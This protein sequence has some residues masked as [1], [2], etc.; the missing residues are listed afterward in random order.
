[1]LTLICITPSIQTKLFFVLFL[2]TA[3][4]DGDVS[5]LQGQLYIDRSRD[6]AYSEALRSAVIA[7]GANHNYFN[8]EWTPGLAVAPSNDDWWDSSDPVCGDTG[9]V[10]LTAQQQQKVG[11]AYTIALVRLAVNQERYEYFSCFSTIVPIYYA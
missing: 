6:I 4:C 7:I 1:L 10:R 8:T 5:D 3:T 2:L 9:S 11:S